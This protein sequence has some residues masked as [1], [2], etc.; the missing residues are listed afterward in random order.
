MNDEAPTMNTLRVREAITA[1]D[2]A[3]IALDW[4]EHYGKGI[5]S[6]GQ[7]ASV[8]VHLN[9]ASACSGSKEAEKTLAAYARLELPSIVD[10]AIISCGN[11]IKMCHGIIAEEAAKPCL[12][13]RP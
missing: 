1:L 5:S 11:T 3:R 9:H 4:L 12:S 10:T 13:E 8:S 2:E 6:S 7:E